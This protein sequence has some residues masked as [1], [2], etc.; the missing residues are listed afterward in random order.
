MVAEADLRRAIAGAADALRRVHDRIYHL[1]GRNITMHTQLRLRQSMARAM[2]PRIPSHRRHKMMR[3]TLHL[4]L[5]LALLVPNTGCPDP[6]PLIEPQPDRFVVASVTVGGPSEPLTVGQTAQLTATVKDQNGNVLTDK[7]VAWKSSSEAVATVSNAGLATAVGPGTATITATVEN[8]SGELPLTVRAP[9]PGPDNQVAAIEVTPA[10]PSVNVG[11]T[12]QLSATAKNA[13]GTALSGV[14]FVWAS[15]KPGIA[16]VDAE[17]GMV[18]GVA[19]GSATVSASAG[20]KTGSTTVVVTEP[21]P[22]STGT[23]AYTRK[24]ELRLIEPDGSGDRLVWAA[25]PIDPAR[26]ELKWEVSA[27]AW[28][29]DG[30]E[31]AFASNHQTATSFYQQDIYA[32]RP[33]GSGLRKLTNAPIHENLATYP[34]GTVTVRVLNWT[35][36]GG[37]YFVYVVGAK[38]PQ[39]VTIGGGSATELTFTDVADFGDERFQHAVV[40]NGLTRWWDAAVAADVKPGSTVH[41]GTVTITQY[42]GFANFGAK[43][44]FWRSDGT[45]IGFFRGPGCMLLQVPSNPRIGFYNDPIF[46]PEVFE[47]PCA[48]AWGPASLADQ[49]LVVDDRHVY[50]VTE[51]SRSRGT[52]VATFDRTV[53]AVDIRWLPDGSGFLVARPDGLLD[54]DINLYEFSFETGELRKLTDFTG[55]FVRSFSLSPDGQSIVFERVSGG[56]IYDLATLPADVWVMN[57]DGS[58]LRL[59]V[60]D[61]AYPDWNPQR[62]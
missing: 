48:A 23:I 51:G 34:K 55:E 50:R 45:R 59:L 42:G 35:M 10:N 61:A 41:A 38:E 26:P 27:P 12:L 30:S 8:R 49:M 31:I 15:D 57:R 28:R 2:D 24:D 33:D 36:D 29:P 14:S 46:D 21:P 1:F 25:P 18:K 20:G 19:A 3:I 22:T 7:P 5:Y 16:S 37:P 39:Q 6:E 52:L 53:R 56:S 13:S 62:R 44:P 4:C 54:E 60:R 47:S 11:A 40:I 32:I 17:G 58:D 9:D 43:S